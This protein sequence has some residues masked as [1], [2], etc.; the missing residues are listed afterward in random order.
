MATKAKRQRRNAPK[1]EIRGTGIT[2]AEVS[3]IIDRAAKRVYGDVPPE[4]PKDY[5]PSKWADP[6]PEMAG[7]P[8]PARVLCLMA[9]AAS[10]AFAVGLA[11]AVSKWAGW[12]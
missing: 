9:G 2:Q 8:L 6:I 11:W 4:P 3:Q 10:G 5:A 7:A 12:A 1:Q